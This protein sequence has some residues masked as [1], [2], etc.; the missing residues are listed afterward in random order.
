MLC[1]VGLECDGRNLIAVATNR[2]VLGASRA[3]FTGPKFEAVIPRQ[4]VEL[5][6]RVC[7][8]VRGRDLLHWVDFARGEDNVALQFFGGLQITVPTVPKPPA[9]RGKGGRFL[10]RE[11]TFP[12]WRQL[13]PLVSDS[14]N[15]E[16]S[17]NPE[18]MAQFAHVD[19]GG[20]YGEKRMRVVQPTTNK[21]ILIRIGENFIGILMPIR[22]ND[23]DAPLRPA[24]LGD[25]PKPESTAEDAPAT[26]AG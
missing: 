25:A 23:T 10:P 6:I 21:Q 9:L 11:R 4:F 3:E 7:K 24:W 14:A 2:F 22:A 12:A 1:G 15:S 13:I 16:F 5:L 26:K 18:Y 17:V 19:T 20:S 8:T